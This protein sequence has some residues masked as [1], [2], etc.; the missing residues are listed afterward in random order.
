MKQMLL[1]RK[2]HARKY[3]PELRSFAITLQFYSTKAYNYIRKVWGNVLPHPA[4]LRGWY[5]VVNGAPGFSKEP[6]EAISR[7]TQPVCNIVMDEM[8]IKEQILF[9]HGK[10]YGGV[11]LG[12]GLDN[13]GDNAELAKN[14]LVF[15]AVALNGSWKVPLGYFLIKGLT[16]SDRANLLT[17]CLELMHDA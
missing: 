5:R 17:K 3:L 15:M 14:A 7:K 1:R 10:F 9:S 6:Y 8:S 16:A 11:N 13:S 12:T 2:R 4:T